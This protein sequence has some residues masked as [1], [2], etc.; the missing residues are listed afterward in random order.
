MALNPIL[1]INVSFF[2]FV[3]SIYLKKKDVLVNVLK[4]ERVLIPILLLNQR[5][6]VASLRKTS[7]NQIMS[8]D[9]SPALFSNALRSRL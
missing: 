3:G 1:P 5:Q 7:V 9:H 4:W 2:P 8:P 6:D